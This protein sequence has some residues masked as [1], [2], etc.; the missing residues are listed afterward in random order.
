MPF[1]SVA[2]ALWI[3]LPFAGM[4]ADAIHA[5]PVYT[6]GKGVSGMPAFPDVEILVEL[7]LS[8]P[9]A[10]PVRDSFELHVDGGAGIPASQVRSL[11]E[12]GHGMAASIAL[13]ASGSMKG[14][15]LNAVRTGLTKFVTQAGPQDRVA[16]QTFADESRWDVNWGDSPDQIRTAIQHL[17]SR[18]SQTVLWD[19]LLEALA[20]FPDTPL[21]RRLI[22]ISDGH[23]E[24]SRHSLQEVIAEAIRLHIPVDGIGITRDKRIYLDNLA[25]L[26]ARTGGQFRV[27]RNEAE[28]E[29]FVGN[30]VQRLKSLPVVSFRASGVPS[31][32]R[33]HT[34]AVTWK[35]GDANLVAETVAGV[36][37]AQSDA[38]PPAPHPTDHT[39]P[40]Q[41]DQRNRKILLGAI[42]MLALIL[43]VALALYFYLSRP[44]PEAKSPAAAGPAAVP[45]SAAVPIIAPFAS[46]SNPRGKTT[47]GPARGPAPIPFDPMAA[48]MPAPA[49]AAPVVPLARAGN[50]WAAP[51]GREVT[52]IAVRFSPPSK[53][54]PTAWLYAEDGTA[55]GQWYPIESTEYWIGALPQ[56][57]IAMAADPTVS[58]HHACIALDGDVLAIWDYESTNGT[59]VNGLPL[60]GGR[61]LLRPGDRVRIGRTTLT[62]HLTR[63]KTT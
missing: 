50:E 54:N 14:G 35:H 41:P 10:V 37:T 27:A 32:G 13:D 62:L 1:Q 2:W 57:N 45:Q 43:I 28:L 16:I 58:G 47:P 9:P 29:Q 53:G 6:A 55:S 34:F 61:R 4:A 38:P 22:V 42:G 59:F 39:E 60:S 11:E 40:N 44:K 52:Q 51:A 31:D 46:D 63:E 15:P 5:G 18:G 20:K 12:S 30:G 19:A 24:G 25:N 7:P 36:P 26:A 3:A 33:S 8:N 21:A 23:D 49:A 48:P 17:A 56:N